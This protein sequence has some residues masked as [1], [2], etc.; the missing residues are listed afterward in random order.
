ML[1]DR[2]VSLVDKV[3]FQKNKRKEMLM[4][5]RGVKMKEKE[6]IDCE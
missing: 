4:N 5:G 3:S 6:E 2:V 1:H